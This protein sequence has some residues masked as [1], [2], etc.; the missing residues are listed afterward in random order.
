MTHAGLIDV[1]IF[2][3]CGIMLSYVFRGPQAQDVL[4][5]GHLAWT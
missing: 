5:I 1:S 4:H 3:R 2:E